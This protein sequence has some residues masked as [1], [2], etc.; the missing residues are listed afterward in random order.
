MS[1]SLQA[2][3]VHVR[4]RR[5]ADEQMVLAHVFHRLSNLVPLLNVHIFKDDWLRSFHH[6]IP[7]S[8]THHAP[9][10]S[11]P[12]YH[13]ISQHPPTTQHPAFLK[14]TPHFNTLSPSTPTNHLP[15]LINVTTAPYKF[16]VPGKYA[17]SL[18]PNV[19]MMGG[20]M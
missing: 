16:P 3:S 1:R 17:N 6:P 9:I 12:H 4:V 19:D 10:S 7:S 5:D 14:Q 15:S 20:Q 13:N 18:L 8:I 11:V 2:G